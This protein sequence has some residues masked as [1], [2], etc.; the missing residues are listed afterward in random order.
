MET[1]LA[2]LRPGAGL[3]QDF[4]V[5]VKCLL[6][7]NKDPHFAHVTGRPCDNA[8]ILADKFQAS[9]TMSIGCKATVSPGQ[10]TAYNLHCLQYDG[11]ISYA[12]L[13]DIH[14]TLYIFR[15]FPCCF[16]STLTIDIPQVERRFQSDRCTSVGKSLVLKYGK[17]CGRNVRRKYEGGEGWV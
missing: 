12:H 17:L 16:N 3:K 5:G 11:L 15:I 14:L 10:M 2:L 9:C 7:W 4:E 1:S 6:P 8:H 13:N